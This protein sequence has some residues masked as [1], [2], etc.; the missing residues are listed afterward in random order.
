MVSYFFKQ[1]MNLCGNACKEVVYKV[2]YK[3]ITRNGVYAE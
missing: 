2:A 1:I 3:F